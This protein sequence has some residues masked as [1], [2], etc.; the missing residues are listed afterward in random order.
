MEFGSGILGAEAPVDGGLGSVA[1]CF[2]GIDGFSQSQLAPV[3]VPA[4]SLWST[5]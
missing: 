5:R 4:H 1:S 3:G 2:V